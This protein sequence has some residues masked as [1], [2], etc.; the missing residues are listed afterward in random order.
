MNSF[1]EHNGIQTNKSYFLD[2]AKSFLGSTF[3]KEAEETRKQKLKSKFKERRKPKV[4]EATPQRK[5][6]VRDEEIYSH[7]DFYTRA[8]NAVNKK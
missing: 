1:I 6:A 2:D 8:L 7:H 3:D 5:T 4:V